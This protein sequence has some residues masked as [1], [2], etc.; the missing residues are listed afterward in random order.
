[1]LK[2]SYLKRANESTIYF[3]LVWG[4]VLLAGLSQPIVLLVVSAC[5]GGAMMFLYS[6][7]LVV[8]NRKVLPAEVGITRG[9]RAALVWAFLLFGVLS[10]LTIIDEVGELVGADEIVCWPGAA[11][12]VLHSA[13][14]RPVPQ[15]SVPRAAGAGV[16]FPSAALLCLRSL[17]LPGVA[18][19]LGSRRCRGSL[20]Q[21]AL[22]PGTRR[23]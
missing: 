18:V 17:L 4:L 16:A 6:A 12:A 1:M 2:T 21:T 20:L 19:Q 8:L 9:R 3:A 22:P 11:L 10:V 15:P 7:L 13:S 23:T 5:V 14:T